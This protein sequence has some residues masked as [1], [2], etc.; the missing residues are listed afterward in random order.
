M[1]GQELDPVVAALRGQISARDLE[2]LAALNARLELVARLRAHKD[3]SGLP[4]LDPRR[5]AQLLEDLQRANAGPLSAEGLRE[6]Y[7]EILALTKRELGR[8]EPGGR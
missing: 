3:R 5:E 4:F 7:T 8:A 6:I 2:L 1:S